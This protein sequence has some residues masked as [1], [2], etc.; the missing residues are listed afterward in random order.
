MMLASTR[1]RP[2]LQAAPKPSDPATRRIRS[3]LVVASL[4]SA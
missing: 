4:M 3:S 2:L 1:S